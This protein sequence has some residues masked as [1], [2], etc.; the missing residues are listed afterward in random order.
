VILES[1]EIRFQ[2]G[3][4]LWTLLG[5]SRRSPRH[6]SWLRIGKPILILHSASAQHPRPG[7]LWLLSLGT[8]SVSNFL[9]TPTL[10]PGHAFWIH[11]GCLWCLTGSN[12]DDLVQVVFSQ[13]MC[14]MLGVHWLACAW[15]WFIIG[16][17][18]KRCRGTDDLVAP[19]GIPLDLL[20]RVMIIRT[21]PYSQEE[22][23][24][25]C[26]YSTIC[27]L[28]YLLPS[29]RHRLSEGWGQIVRTLLR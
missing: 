3:D 13:G 18:C 28:N 17:S 14:A 22:M 8:F 4:L 16:C 2:H 27:V 21:M 19:H 7:R 24:Q 25:V 1:T 29:S 26:C 6:P 10:D 5:S 11:P 15:L 23:Q 20:D 9:S 12:E